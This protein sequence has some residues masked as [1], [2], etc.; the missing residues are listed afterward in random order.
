MILRVYE[1]AKELGVP[2]GE[3]M[4]VAREAG[5]F[6][7]SASSVLTDEGAVVI[8]TRYKTGGR[9]PEATRRNPFTSPREGSDVRPR[10]VRAPSRERRERY[11]GTISL[12]ARVMLDHIVLPARATFDRGKP[13]PEEVR[14]ANALAWD[15]ACHGFDEK[16]AQPW[17]KIHREIAP[18]TA[19]ALAQAGLTA[20]DAALR[21]W[22]AMPD[23]SRPR[24]AQRV[25]RGDLTAE[26]AKEELR[27]A[28][29][30]HE[31]QS[32]P[33]PPKPLRSGSSGRSRGGPP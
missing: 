3:V 6:L 23:R 16:E 13:W 7:R 27:R 31:L 19:R 26:Q 1:L 33:A 8:R 9:V 11:S 29:Y 28:I 2:S 18:R 20:W 25:A 32:A 30:L 15:W 5:L 21:I 14:K 10:P 12:L 24:L 22:N 17:V 4:Q